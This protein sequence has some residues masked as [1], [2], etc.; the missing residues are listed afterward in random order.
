MLYE[1][2]VKLDNDRAETFAEG[3]AEIFNRFDAAVRLSPESCWAGKRQ[4]LPAANLRF[5][6]VGH[7]SHLKAVI[8]FPFFN[9]L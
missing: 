9:V 5:I 8:A 3:F 6:V 1:A 7:S 2:L 4:S